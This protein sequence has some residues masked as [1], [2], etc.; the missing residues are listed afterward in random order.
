MKFAIQK[1]KTRFH[2]YRIP[3]K[4]KKSVT[5]H[6]NK[7]FYWCEC[8]DIKIKYLLNKRIVYPAKSLYFDSFIFAKFY[9]LPKQNLRTFLKLSSKFINWKKGKKIIKW[10]LLLEMFS[11]DEDYSFV[12]L[13][14]IEPFHLEVQE[15]ITLPYSYD[16]LIDVLGEPELDGCYYYRLDNVEFQLEWNQSWWN[17][18]FDISTDPDTEL[19]IIETFSEYLDEK[20]SDIHEQESI[21][22]C[23]SELTL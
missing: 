11:K 22:D 1:V 16:D 15:L 6:L 19:D 7:F 18:M 14:R 8:K 3:N 17:I 23:L 5:F 21:L 12:S 4:E 10:K 2:P 20:I 9:L 13:K